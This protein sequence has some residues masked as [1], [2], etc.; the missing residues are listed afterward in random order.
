MK[1]ILFVMNVDWNWI[2]QR[3][4]F[5]AEGL[6]KDFNTKI[7]YQ[8]HYNRKSFQK[9]GYE[10]YNVSAMYVIPRIDRNRK[11]GKINSFLR[12]IYYW[13]YLKQNKTDILYLTYPIQIVSVPSNYKGEIIYDCM[14]D[15]PMFGVSC[16]IKDELIRNE[17]KICKLAKKV[18][19]S[20]ENLKSVLIKRYGDSI[21]KKIEVIRNGFN[22]QIFPYNKAISVQREKNTKIFCYFGTIAEWFDFSLLVKSLED[23]NNIKYVLY[24][25]ANVE[26]PRHER[27][28]YKG[29]IEHDKLYDACK[30]VDCF[31]MPFILNDVIESV[32]PV[33]LYEY[34]NFG[35]RIISVKYNEIMRFEPFIGMYNNYE[36]YKDLIREICNNPAPAYQDKDRITFLNN[37]S[38][39]ERIKRI[40]NLVL[41]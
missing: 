8:H 36:E 39:A 30:D 29:T 18:I 27:I 15:Y 9:R 17:D 31:I 7:I 20:S 22:G 33:K 38:W 1:N 32:D 19:C 21:E 2:K 23:F 11:L 6:S 40:E 35:K 26:I 25:P 13:H 14:D 24:G 28:E 4:H 12:R 5:I 16:N 34:L 41:K 3:P 37:N 10:N